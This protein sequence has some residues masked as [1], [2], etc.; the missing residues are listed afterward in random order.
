MR[1]RDRT[2]PLGEYKGRWTDA[3]DE[4]CPC[5][6]CYNAHNCARSSA[7]YLSNPVMRCA[8][9][10][11]DGCPTP[12]PSS[13]HLYTPRGRVCQRCGEHRQPTGAIQQ[14]AESEEGAT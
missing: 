12:M 2:L 3:R 7:T 5:R 10:E 14:A 1:V 11:N 6:P 9:R 13:A 8:T 4:S